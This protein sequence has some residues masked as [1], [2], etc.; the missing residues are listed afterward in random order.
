MKPTLGTIVGHLS[1]GFG[2]GIGGES[3]REGGPVHTPRWGRRAPGAL[4][5][6]T[7]AAVTVAGCGAAAPP[8]QAAAP[9]EPAGPAT[10]LTLR[11]PESVST[12]SAVVATPPT[13]PPGAT[14]S[15]RPPATETTP[16]VTEPPATGGEGAAG[17]GDGSDAPAEAADDGAAPALATD[18]ELAA[19]EERSAVLLNELRTGVGLEPV[20]GDAEMDAYAREWSRHMAETGEFAHSEGAYGENIAFTSDVQ[21]TAAEAAERFHDLWVNSPDHLANMTNPEFT[22]VGVGLYRT[23]RGWYGTHVFI[24]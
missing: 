16:A 20:A 3:A 24:Y 6:L 15:T 5:A 17:G 7:L 23:E 9:Q 8:D 22:L 11:T 1:A 13:L 10:E 12:S 4:L 14:T 18:E 21:L 2:R 19:G